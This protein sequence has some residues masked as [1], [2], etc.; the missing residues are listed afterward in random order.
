MSLADAMGVGM[1]PEPEVAAGGFS[2]EQKVRYP[3]ALCVCARA[4]VRARARDLCPD[5]VCL[6]R[7]T[8]SSSPRPRT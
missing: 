7:W 3:P 8:T 5:S 2:A 6:A 1:E 4:W